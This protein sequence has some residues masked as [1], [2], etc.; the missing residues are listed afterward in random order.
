MGR[1][2]PREAYKTVKLWDVKS[3][4]LLRDVDGV[5][6]PVYSVSFS[7]D[8]RLLA[9]ASFDQTIKISDVVSGKL[10]RTL[11]GHSAPVGPV[12]FSP[13]GRLLVAG[14]MKE[15][16]LWDAESGT[17]LQTLDAHADDVESVAF[18]P[19]GKMV[20][21]Y[22]GLPPFRPGRRHDAWTKAQLRRSAQDQ[23][24]DGTC[25]GSVSLRPGPA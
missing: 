3:G 11:Q 24:S 13:D 8:G 1:C 18:S 22:G 6:D 10:L 7:P 20:T 23:R 4:A 15:I 14:A 12:A 25:P 9:S 17:L 21:P 5:S 19:D 16:K 2:L